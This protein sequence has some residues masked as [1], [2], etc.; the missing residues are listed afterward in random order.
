MASR[1]SEVNL[2][3]DVTTTSLQKTAVREKTANTKA[4]MDALGL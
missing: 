3:K 2:Y 1:L 4:K